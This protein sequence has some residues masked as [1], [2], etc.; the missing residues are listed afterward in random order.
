MY[1]PGKRIVL[2]HGFTKKSPR[3]PRLDLEIARARY[4]SAAAEIGEPS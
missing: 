2:L 4:H 3:T 1:A